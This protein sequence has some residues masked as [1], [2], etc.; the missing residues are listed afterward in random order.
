MTERIMTHPVLGE[1]DEGDQLSF[2]FNGTS[3]P[4]LKSDTIA[5]ALLANDIRILR[6]HETSG[7]PR[8]IYCNIGHCFE[9]R[10]TVNGEPGVR[11]CLIAVEEHMEVQA[12]ERFPQDGGAADA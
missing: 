9:C 7:R 3:Y 12:G 1:I 11:A 5:S 4:A 10:V 2:T 6:H 8:G